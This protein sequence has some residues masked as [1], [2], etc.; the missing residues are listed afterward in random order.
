ML[1]RPLPSVPYLLS[2]PRFPRKMA[3][4]YYKRPD[5][6]DFRRLQD[7]IRTSAICLPWLWAF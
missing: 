3:S 5:D 2:M 4:I 6:E 1:A 7:E